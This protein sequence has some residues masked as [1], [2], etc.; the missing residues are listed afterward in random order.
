MNNKFNLGDIV[1]VKILKG[2]LEYDSLTQYHD[3]I[4]EVADVSEA[5]RDTY[6]YVLIEPNTSKRYQFYEDDLILHTDQ[7]PIKPVSPLIG[8]STSDLIEELLGRGEGTVI[9]H[10][11]IEEECEDRQLNTMT[12]AVGNKIIVNGIME[13]L[14][15]HVFNE[16]SELKREAIDDDES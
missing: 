10:A 4:L 1:Q 5:I 11:F 14:R 6:G 7:G 2:H 13:E 12:K 9:C 15:E 3:L 8:F 16:Y